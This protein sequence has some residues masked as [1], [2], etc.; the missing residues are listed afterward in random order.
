MLA[1][2]RR[3]I[4][5]EL[6][7]RDGKVE[8]SRLRSLFNVSDETLRR[9]LELLYKEGLAI[10]CYG[11]A[12]LNGNAND[13]SFSTRKAQ[14]PAQKMK[15]AEKVLDLVA[16]GDSIMLDASSTAVYIA[17]M[18]KKKNDLTIVT[19]SME[20]MAEL[21]EK[22]DFTI[23]S[24][25]GKLSGPF[26]AFTG[27]QALATLASF[28]VNKLIFS[29]KALNLDGGVFDSTGEFADVKQ[30]MIRAANTRILVAD[31]AKFNRTSFAK[32]TDL[33]E[34][35]VVVTDKKPNN[36]WVKALSANNTVVI[37]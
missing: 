11:G 27:G 1:V 5:L 2:E 7:L 32:I 35:D 22:S 20:V 18:L 23:I 28:H 19:N 9:D 10:K 33:N 4:I 24:T 8:I 16:D 14:N 6:L 34:I 12:T 17:K 30:A 25:G 26:L 37:F 3:K 21:A 36:A 13:V 15:I 29:C 31:S